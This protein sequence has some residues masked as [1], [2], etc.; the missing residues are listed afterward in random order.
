[1]V[2][3]SKLIDK[4]VKDN[5]MCTCVDSVVT[6]LINIRDSTFEKAVTK[7]ETNR[8]FLHL[9]KLE[10]AILVLFWDDVLERFNLTNKKLQ[11]ISIDLITVSNLYS[12]LINHVKQ[13]R[14]ISIFELYEKKT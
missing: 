12:F 1:L 13:L 14:S 11:S 3:G 9:N 8:I 10:T 5:I 6:S 7:N 4:I 2:G